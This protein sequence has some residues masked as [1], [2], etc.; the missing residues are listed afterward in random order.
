MAGCLVVLICGFFLGLSVSVVVDTV[1]RV[2]VL[3]F[4][5]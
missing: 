2:V 3:F 1:H 4:V 5:C